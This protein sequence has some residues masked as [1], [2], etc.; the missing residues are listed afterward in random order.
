[1]RR[2]TR[3]C[4]KAPQPRVFFYEEDKTMNEYCVCML[5][6]ANEQIRFITFAADA[7]DAEKKARKYIPEIVRLDKTVLVNMA[8]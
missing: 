2:K 6:P 4:G 5:T 7:E 8:F 3:G 1:M